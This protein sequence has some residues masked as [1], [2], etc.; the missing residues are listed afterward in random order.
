VTRVELA[1]WGALFAVSIVVLVKA[2]DSFTDSAER[3]GV[4]L[5]IPSFITGVTIVAIGTSLPELVSSVVAVLRDTSEIVVGNVVGSNVTNIFLV[6]GVAAIMGRQLRVTYEIIHVD[7]PLLVGSA[8]MMAWVVWDGMV[9]PHEALALLAGAVIYV[10]YAIRV[11][12][13]QHSFPE[14]EEE[15]ERPETPAVR[16]W[17]VLLASAGFVYVGATFT[18]ESVIRL[19]DILGIGTEI[20]AISAVALGTS[21]P[22]LTVSIVAAR[23]GNL[24]TAMGNVLGSSVFNTFAV[25]GIPALIGDL[26]IPDSVLTFGLPVM[27]GATLLYFFMAQDKEVSR[28]EGWLLVVFYGLFVV[29]LFQMA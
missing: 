16:V 15:H 17:V 4:F 18:V 1:G 7:L 21:L 9:A 14:G 22:E 5:G 26:V 28:W 6:L 19:A 2:A 8:F 10:L 27:V 20:I 29:E 13:R 23:R 11:S 24:E 25:M 12:R 3:I